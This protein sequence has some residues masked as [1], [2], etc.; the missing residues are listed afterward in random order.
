[1]RVACKKM[2]APPK[3][4]PEQRRAHQNA[5]ATKF[6]AD[7]LAWAKQHWDAEDARLTAKYSAYGALAL[8]GMRPTGHTHVI[9]ARYKAYLASQ[10]TTENG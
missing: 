6:R 1:M 5:K 7:S 10:P 8:L 4:T 3:Q 2:S 9:Q